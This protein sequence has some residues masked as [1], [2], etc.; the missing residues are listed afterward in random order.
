MVNGTIES[1]TTNPNYYF[2]SPT[3]LKKSETKVKMSFKKHLSYLLL[4]SSAETDLWHR[5]LL[6]LDC[7]GEPFVL[8]SFLHHTLELARTEI[9]EGLF[10]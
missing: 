5:C 8:G 10:S 4:A 9:Y 6:T 7:G 2:G 1:M 3:F